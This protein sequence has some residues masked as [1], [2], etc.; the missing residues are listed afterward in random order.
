[1]KYNHFTEKKWNISKCMNTH[2]TGEEHIKKPNYSD[3][4]YNSYHNFNIEKKCNRD[5]SI[6]KIN[7]SLPHVFNNSLPHAFNNSVPHA[8][9]N[10]LPHAFNNRLPHAFNNSYS[11]IHNSYENRTPHFNKVVFKLNNLLEKKFIREKLQYMS[12]LYY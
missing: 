3:N 4:N 2:N 8:F 10:R 12:Y 6:L 1:M 7:N 5:I 9:N 11:C